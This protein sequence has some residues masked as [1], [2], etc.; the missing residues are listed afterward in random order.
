MLRRCTVLKHEKWRAGCG[1]WGA[2]IAEGGSVAGVCVNPS[3]TH[4]LT[5]SILFSLQS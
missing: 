5:H 4:A 1:L 3:L 2:R